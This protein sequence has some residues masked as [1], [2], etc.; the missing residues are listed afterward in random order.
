MSGFD[1]GRSEQGGGG[2]YC[3]IHSDSTG[4]NVGLSAYLD[5][6]QISWDSSEE[7]SALTV[8]TPRSGAGGDVVSLCPQ[9]QQDPADPPE[10]CEAFWTADEADLMI[11]LS[12]SGPGAD[13]DTVTNQL[14]TLMPTI[15]ATLAAADPTA[16]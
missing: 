8:G 5:P 13:A 16:F 1:L 11:S 15:L 10:H 3:Y 7:V 14:L 6:N 2:V 12:Y 4:V 9:E